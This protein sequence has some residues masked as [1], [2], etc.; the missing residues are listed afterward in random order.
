MNVLMILPALAEAGSPHFRP[1]KY[2]LFPPLGLATLAAYLDPDDEIELIDEHVEPVP[3]DRQPD[4][5]VIEVYITAARRA[6]ALAD[7]YR[8]KGAHVC[9]GGLHVTSLPAE[10]ARHGDTVFAGPGEEMWPR[11]LRDF[12][13]GCARRLYRG[14]ERTLADQP[15]PRRD[16]IKRG[17]YLVPNSLLVSRGCPGHCDFCYKDSFYAGGRSYYVQPL[18][19][20]LAE[21]SR[22]P[23]RHVFFL[24]DNLFAGRRYAM[25]LFTAMRGMGRV[26]QGA[27]TVQSA[28]DAGLLDRAVD[29]GLRSL[30]LGFETLDDAGLREQNKFHSRRQDYEKVIAMLRERG[31]M[32]NASFVFGT[33]R[34]GPD[35]FRRTTDW[36]I[37]QGIETAT[38]HILTPYPGTRLHARMAAQG[39]ILTREWDL[40]DTR[41]AVFQPARMTPE[42]LE[43]G[44]WAAYRQFY[45]WPAIIRAA[46]VKPGIIGPLRHIAY[47]GGW[48]KLEP[49]WDWIIRRGLLARMRPVLERV[50]DSGEQNQISLPRRTAQPLLSAVPPPAIPAVAAQGGEQHSMCDPVHGLVRVRIRH[51]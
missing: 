31:V 33:D 7:H 37:S 5:V 6:Y 46:S 9:L 45:R 17:N 32:V 48:K 21:I 13:A 47:S 3:L 12:R 11:F 36:A 40:Y 22:L 41:H 28:L 38:F 23:G 27:A 26:W 25:D 8:A 20:A 18:D 15:S 50:L 10:A 30:F 4:L 19:E 43:A 1:I 29:S 44:Y 2:S 51:K 24:D 42:Q 39:R 14:E 49:L 16:L 35:V 34:D